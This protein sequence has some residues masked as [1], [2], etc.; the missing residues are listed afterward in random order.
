MPPQ[1]RTDPASGVP[2]E[3]TGETARGS[4]AVLAGRADREPCRGD[5]HHREVRHG[6]NR[7]FVLD[8][9]KQPLMPCTPARAR[10]LLAAGKAAVYR[11]IPFTIL[12]QDREGGATQPIAFKVDPGSKTSGVVLGAEFERGP[13]VI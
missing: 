13:T 11:R 10:Q 3:P 12:L 7:G 1:S 8:R 5:L 6:G 4:L 2:P 9:N